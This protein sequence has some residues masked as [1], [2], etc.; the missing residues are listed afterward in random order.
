[1]LVPEP[2]VLITC[3]NQDL[4]PNEKQFL[5]GGTRNWL[6]KPWIK[7]NFGGKKVLTGE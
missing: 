6:R 3:L 5:E 7:G 1:M 4:L 2:T